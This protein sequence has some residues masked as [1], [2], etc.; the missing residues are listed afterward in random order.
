LEIVEKLFHHL[1]TIKV[2]DKV[3]TCESTK[4]KPEKGKNLPTIYEADH[5]K[6]PLNS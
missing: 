2:A 5:G 4:E 3:Q 1:I 6:Q